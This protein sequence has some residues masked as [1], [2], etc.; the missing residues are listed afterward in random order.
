MEQKISGP[1]ELSTQREPV[2]HK[3]I[4]VEDSFFIYSYEN[5]FKCL[6]RH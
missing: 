2:T 3:L 1:E 4:I 5:P 6:Q